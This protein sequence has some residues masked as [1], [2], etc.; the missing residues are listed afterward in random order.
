MIRFGRH[1]MLIVML[2][3]ILLITACEQEQSEVDDLNE[4]MKPVTLV[5]LLDQTDLKQ[6]EFM[7][8][9]AEPI[10]QKY[11]HITVNLQ[12]NID[13][14][15]GLE[16]R[17]IKGQFPD[18]ILTTERQINDHQN[19]LT[20]LDLGPYVD[21]YGMNL[22]HFHPYAI[23]LPRLYSQNDALIALPFT[24]AFSAL[25]YN[26]DIFENT[27]NNAPTDG[28][29]WDE[30]IALSR[31]TFDL[32]G[33]QYHGL[34]IPKLEDLANQ[35]S[36]HYIDPKTGL[37]KIDTEDW[38]NVV[39][40]HNQ[41]LAIPQNARATASGFVEHQNVAML[42]GY[43][44]VIQRIED[45]Y[46]RGL[47]MWWDMVQYP[48][49]ANNDNTALG[50]SGQYFIVS[51]ISKYKEDAF[52]ALTVLTGEENQL[53]LSKAGR[54]SSLNLSHIQEAFGTENPFLQGRNIKGVFASDPAKP[55][56][57]TTFDYLAI[58]PL[59]E[60]GREIVAEQEDVNTIFRKAEEKINILL[61][62]K[63]EGF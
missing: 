4:E 44:T 45:L 21:R 56:K 29:T 62:Q 17:I 8:W 3:L 13:G 1:I 55:Y 19:M 25:F 43:S 51:S 15:A 63:K 36:L 50:I 37:A 42:A 35:R 14:L 40:M 31:R 2:S 7:K 24:L 26:V 59:L 61:S 9:I 54:W 47:T 5:L 53:N 28:M 39:M 23:E 22:N 11:P 60:A 49:Y 34:L 16:Q 20:A 32:E 52:R 30:V 58:E 57:A 48:S 33:E 46:E 12:R 6:E 38:I 18:M 41:L 27:R 10:K